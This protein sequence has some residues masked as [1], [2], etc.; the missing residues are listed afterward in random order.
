MDYLRKRLRFILIF[1]F[2][3]IIFGVV[4]WFFMSDAH[5][6]GA[7]VQLYGQIL[8]IAC[9][10]FALYAVISFFRVK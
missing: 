5:L 7:R 1:I 4:Q 6:T 2:S 3:L 8:K 10:G 9:G